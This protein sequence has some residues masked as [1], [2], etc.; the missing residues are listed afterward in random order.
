MGY[1]PYNSSSEE[2]HGVGDVCTHYVPR[3]ETDIRELTDREIAEETLYWLRATGQAL[4][5]FQ[6]GG[7]GKMIGMLSGALPRSR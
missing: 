3:A 2:T 1:P 5:E 6:S 4:R 7:M